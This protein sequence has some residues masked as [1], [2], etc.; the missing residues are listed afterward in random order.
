MQTALCYG[1]TCH[2]K[3]LI[4][5]L[6]SH[7]YTCESKQHGLWR[8]GCYFQHARTQTHTQNGPVKRLCSGLLTSL[9][10]IYIQLHSSNTAV[11]TVD[12]GYTDIHTFHTKSTILTARHTFH[13]LRKNRT[14]NAA[15]K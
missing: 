10:R 5:K 9:S 4:T 14:Q 11:N 12:I 1:K 13:Q 6:V 15:V 8:Y 3:I 7:E 2:I